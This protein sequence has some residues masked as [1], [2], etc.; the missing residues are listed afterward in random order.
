MHWLIPFAGA[1]SPA[2]GEAI[3]GLDLPHLERLLARMA[4]VRSPDAP[5]MPAA[6]NDSDD[7]A[8]C[9]TPPH[10]RALAAAW[11]W[12][13]QADGLLPMAA[14]W[15]VTDGLD[16]QP[17][18]TGW[19]LLSPTHW[20]VG[21]DQVSLTHPDALQLDE[22]SA[23]QVFD[24]IRPLFD[25]EGLPLQWGAP[26]RWYITHERLAQLPTASLDRVVGRNVDPWLNTHPDA[27]LF[28]RLQAEVQ[29]LLY[30]HPLNEAREADGLLP[31]NSFWL[32]GTGRPQPVSP[33]ARVN[34]DD[35]LRTAALTEDWAAWAE[36]WAAIDAGPLRDVLAAVE[37]GEPVSLTLCGERHARRYEPQTRSFAKRLFGARRQAAGPVLKGL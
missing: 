9:L 21:T 18:P 30:T 12:S 5:S 14:A 7:A 33:A 24:A 20:H 22:A 11:G 37:A 6:N 25:E 29:M 34:L 8:L 32:S 17:G 36:A 26:T 16:V 35:R 19:G 10:E 3:D 15:A 2:A 23:R 28:R 13:P 31:V 4:P 1:S 27:R